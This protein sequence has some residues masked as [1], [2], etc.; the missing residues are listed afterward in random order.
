MEITVISAI[1]ISIK[2]FINTHINQIE[3]SIL[4]SMNLAIFLHFLYLLDT[5]QKY[6]FEEFKSRQI[7]K[8]MFPLCEKPLFLDTDITGII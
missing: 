4:Y 6:H 5:H 1:R 2:I 8:K 3:D 7:M